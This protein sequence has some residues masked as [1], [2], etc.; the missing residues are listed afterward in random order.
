M[1]RE[2]LFPV[3]P[4]QVSEVSDIHVDPSAVVAPKRT[5]TERSERDHV[6]EVVKL[7]LA[8]ATIATAKLTRLGLPSPAGPS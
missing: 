7:I 1:A 6:V 2:G 4:R 3:T 5:E 8:S